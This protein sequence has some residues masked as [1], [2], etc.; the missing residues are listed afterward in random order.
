MQEKALEYKFECKFTFVNVNQMGMV[1]RGHDL[2]FTS[3]ANQIL[4]VVDFGLLDCLDG[5]LE[6][7]KNKIIWSLRYT[8]WTNKPL[9]QFRCWLQVALCHRFLVPVFSIFEIVASAGE[10]FF[11]WCLDRLD[12]R[13][14]HLPKCWDM[15]P[16]FLCPSCC[17]RFWT[18]MIEL[19]FASIKLVFWW[20]FESMIIQYPSSASAQTP[21]ALAPNGIFNE[22]SS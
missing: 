15:S 3:N 19:S 13:P 9:V 12:R 17:G 4:F 11:F 22:N 1:H 2:Y 16:C 8:E 10:F 6:E 18:V 14:F 5:N 21:L 7:V 20:R